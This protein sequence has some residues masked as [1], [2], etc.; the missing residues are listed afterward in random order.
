MNY[1]GSTERGAAFIA[2]I[3]KKPIV[4][5]RIEIDNIFGG[6]HAFIFNNT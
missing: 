5:D 4:N 3:W 6:A 1:E 2:C